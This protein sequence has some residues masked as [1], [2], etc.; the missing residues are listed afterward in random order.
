[1][2]LPLT[3]LPVRSV[4]SHVNGA[5]VAVAV[6][7][8]ILQGLQETSVRDR[9]LGRANRLINCNAIDLFQTGK[10]VLDFLE[11]RHAKVRNAFLLRLR[12]DLH[13]VAALHDDAAYR[14]RARHNLIDADAAFIAGRALAAALRMVDREAGFDIGAREAF[15]QQRFRRDVDGLLAVGAKPASESLSDDEA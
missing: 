4:P 8:A 12:R 2:T 11:A 6:A 3:F 14:L 13:R 5:W 7:V 10:A 9:S 15:L 1:T